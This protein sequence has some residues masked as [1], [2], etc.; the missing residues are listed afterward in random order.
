[1]ET[2]IAGFLG[3]LALVLVA[4]IPIMAVNRRKADAVKDELK[5][6]V[7]TRVGTPNGHGSVIDMLTT[8]LRRVEQIDGRV[9]KVEAGH[10]K[11]HEGTARLAHDLRNVQQGLLDVVTPGQGTTW[12]I[13]RDRDD[14]IGGG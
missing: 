2:V 5:D 13:T 8:I 4:L 6:E 7:R 12:R 14:P 3:A 1:M 9:E 10:E 11:L